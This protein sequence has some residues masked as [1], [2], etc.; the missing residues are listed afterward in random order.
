[1]LDLIRE[2]INN[3]FRQNGEAGYQMDDLVAAVHNAVKDKYVFIH[4]HADNRGIYDRLDAIAGQ[5]AR[6]NRMEN[7]NMTTLA[8]IQTK[9]DATLAQVT[10]A[11]TVDDAVKAVVDGNNLQLTDLR[12]QL[13]AAI[14][15]G[16]TSPADLQKIA[17]TIDAIQQTDMANGAI[18]ADAVKAGT[19]AANQP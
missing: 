16:T 3:F 15:S 4:V 5:L 12:S 18:V 19:P 6:V 11:R 9:A 10:A 2:A 7:M 14:A 1:M 13:A 17:D 8:E